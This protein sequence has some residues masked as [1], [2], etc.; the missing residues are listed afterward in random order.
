M[1]S[2]SR[3]RERLEETLANEEKMRFRLK[4]QEEEVVYKPDERIFTFYQICGYDMKKKHHIRKLRYNEYCELI[5]YKEA[6]IRKDKLEKFTK[7]CPDFKFAI[8]PAYNLD[9]IGFPKDNEILTAQSQ[10]LNGMF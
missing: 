4:T 8:Y 9:V 3:K 1:T 7:K 2:T 6:K 10:I 5:D